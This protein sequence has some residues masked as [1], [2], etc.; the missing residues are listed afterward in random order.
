MFRFGRS[1]IVPAA[2]SAPI[3]LAAAIAFTGCGKPTATDKA[4]ASTE[5]SK[6]DPWEQVARQLRRDNDLAACKVALGQL[7]NDLA[8]RT[9]VPVAAPISDAAATSLQ[10]I[11]PL[12][13][14]DLAEVRAGS[15]SGLDSVYLADC[16]Y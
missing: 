2:L 4:S 11:V 7:N 13:K 15:Y 16:F 3:A 10:A 9:D 14:D 1:T 8:E 6:T 12:S 5:V